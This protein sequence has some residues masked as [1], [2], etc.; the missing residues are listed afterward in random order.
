ME[1]IIK[2]LTD[3]S[4]PAQ[5]SKKQ[6]EPVLIVPTIQDNDNPSRQRVLSVESK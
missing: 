4:S 2:D 1:R 5:T 3:R 6:M